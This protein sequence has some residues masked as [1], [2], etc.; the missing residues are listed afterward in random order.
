MSK[1][2]ILLQWWLG[3]GEA[4]LFHKWQGMILLWSLFF[5]FLWIWMILGN[6][7]ICD[8]GNDGDMNNAVSMYLQ[9]VKHWNDQ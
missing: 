4:C 3:V 5:I 2:C 9:S 6:L 8:N 1:I 7:Q